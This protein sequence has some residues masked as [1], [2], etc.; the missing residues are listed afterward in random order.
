MLVADP[1]GVDVQVGCREGPGPRKGE[2][3]ER[4]DAPGILFVKRA[5]AVE[6][7]GVVEQR[8]A[9]AALIAI[10]DRVTI[11]WRGVQPEQ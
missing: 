1:L 2:I 4:V 6:P 9:D 3:I 7:E 5:R 11:L 8:E 10:G